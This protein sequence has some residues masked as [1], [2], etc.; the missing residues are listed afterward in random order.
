MPKRKTKPESNQQKKTE[1][2]KHALV[3]RCSFLNWKPNAIDTLSSSKSGKYLAL[4]RENV[5]NI[6]VWQLFFEKW[7]LVGT[8]HGTNIPIRAL[9]WSR[10]EEEDIENNGER[11]FGAFLNGDIFEVNL[12]TMA[13]QFK[14]ITTSSSLSTKPT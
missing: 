9:C 8:V 11:L 4:S 2:S 7:R 3:H 5:G 10:E 12:S 6:E 14:S 1:N 13:I